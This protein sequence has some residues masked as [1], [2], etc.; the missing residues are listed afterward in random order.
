MTWTTLHI[1]DLHKWPGSEGDNSVLM[2]ACQTSPWGVYNWGPFSWE[3]RER[4]RK[5]F[6]ESDTRRLVTES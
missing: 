2:G 1:V 5:S 6:M 4:V 3:G